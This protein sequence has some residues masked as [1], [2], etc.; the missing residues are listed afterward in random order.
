MLAHIYIFYSEQNSSIFLR[1]VGRHLPD[2][3]VT[4]FVA[5][6]CSAQSSTCS[7]EWFLSQILIQNCLRIRGFTYRFRVGARR[8]F[9]GAFTK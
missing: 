5:P 9:L 4:E 8:R 3:S 2:C 7:H 1:N 6:Y